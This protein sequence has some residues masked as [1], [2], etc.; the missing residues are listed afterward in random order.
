MTI[1]SLSLD[2]GML[3]R[4]ET[5]MRKRGYPTRSEAFR[6]ALRGF[7]DEGE[8]SLESG[9][10]TLIVSIIYDK[11]HP[12]A[13]LS[14]LQHRYPEIETMLHTHIDEV[15]CLE[16]F[17]AKGSAPRLKEFI[18]SLRKVKGVKVMRF[19]TTSYNV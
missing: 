12:K 4:F 2:Q 7:I 6:E 3:D 14:F 10:N 15:N 1:V 13:G 11:S 19:L 17:V 9:R 8:W 16:I 18:Q 5:L